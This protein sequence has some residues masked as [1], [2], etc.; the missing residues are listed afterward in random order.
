MQTPAS[1]HGPQSERLQKLIAAAGI[2]SRRHAET[3]LK[4]GR[5]SVNDRPAQLGDKADPRLDRIYVDGVLLRTADPPRLLLINKPRGVISS[6]HDPQGRPIVLD[7]VPPELRRGLHPV[8]RLDSES[9]GALLLTNQ[10]QFTLEL[11][12]PRYSHPK[13]YRV[14]VRGRPS[15]AVL[16]HWRRGVPLDECLTQ[17]ARV[18]ELEHEAHRTLLEVVL[19]EGRNRQIRRVA[20]L[21]GHRVIDLQRTAIATIALG[22]LEEGRWRDL[23]AREWNALTRPPR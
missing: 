18:R 23:N 9:R 19:Q 10:G 6:C 5:V 15:R 13:T 8:G 22:S 17:P 20:E 21:L 1:G 2:C 12:H 7:L 16:D 3:L 4:E 14:W 11:T